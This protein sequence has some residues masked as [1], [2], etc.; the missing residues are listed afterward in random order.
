MCQPAE[1]SHLASSA[2]PVPSQEEEEQSVGVEEEQAWGTTTWTPTS[3][4]CHWISKL[5]A[6]R[7]SP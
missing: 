5:P 3:Q 2:S 1:V 6:T 7:L 4:G